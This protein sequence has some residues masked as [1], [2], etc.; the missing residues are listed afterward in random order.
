MKKDTIHHSDNLKVLKRLATS[1]IALI[2]A[3]PPFNS[4]RDYAAEDG[5][6]TDKTSPEQVASNMLAADFDWIHRVATPQETSYYV[7]LI[8]RLQ[9]M[10]RILKPTG[11]LYW[12]CDFR[13]VPIMRLILTQLFGRAQY[14][15]DIAWIYNSM[16][17]YDT[18]KH[19]WK[20]NYD[21]ILFY[22]KPEHTFQ[23]QFHA[24]TY[25]QQKEMYPYRDSSGRRY[26]YPPDKSL[27]EK[28]E[29]ADENRGSRIRSAWTDIPLTP[30]KERTGYPTQKPLALLRRII[31]ASSRENDIVLD[32]YCGSGTTLLAAKQLKRHYIGIDENPEAVHIAKKRLNSAKFGKIRS[33][34]PNRE[35]AVRPTPVR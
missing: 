16:M 1:S 9:E 31:S 21:T 25:K 8:P 19:R 10:H 14:R 23:P 3:D 18:I 30:L 29:Y 5:G 28:K 7:P 22:A 4:G 11:A 32:A 6:F 2:Y 24:L 26:R 13:T 35:T 27:Y 34:A 15:N 17:P 20:N 33:V 12:H